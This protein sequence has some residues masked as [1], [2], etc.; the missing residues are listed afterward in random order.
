MQSAAEALIDAGIDLPLSCEQGVCGTCVT[1]VLMKGIAKI[2]PCHAAHARVRHGWS[3]A[4][5]TVPCCKTKS[6]LWS[7]AKPTVTT[8]H[9]WPHWAG[10]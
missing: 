9:R 4:C 10:R 3:L 5:D 7:A 2:S 1:R 6:N 8:G